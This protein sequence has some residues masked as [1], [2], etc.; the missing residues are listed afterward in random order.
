MPIIFTFH[1]I[2][3]LSSNSQTFTYS[4]WM[5]H[6]TAYRQNC[7]SVTLHIIA[8]FTSP[9]IRIFVVTVSVIFSLSFG[10]TF[11]NRLICNDQ[12]YIRTVCILL[13]L[14]YMVAIILQI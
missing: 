13:E 10:S 4:L 2:L 14:Q 8:C 3:F 6:T 12:Q 7:V 9:F 1:Q 11:S 5:F